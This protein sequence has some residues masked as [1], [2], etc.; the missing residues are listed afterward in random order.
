MR[1]VQ[2]SILWLI[3]YL[4]VIFE[5][6]LNK[7]GAWKA[8]SYTRTVRPFTPSPQLCFSSALGLCQSAGFDLSPSS[9]FPTYSF[10]LSLY[11]DFPSVADF[12]LPWA[13]LVVCEEQPKLSSPTMDDIQTLYQKWKQWLMSLNGLWT[14]VQNWHFVCCHLFFFWE[15]EVTLRV[16]LR[17]TKRWINIF[18]QSTWCYID[19][20]LRLEIET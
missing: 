12:D 10:P 17:T 7:R 16:E 15:T 2:M 1:P 19:K 20:D 11:F 6:N 13:M 9:H 18:L 8:L 4:F 14:T 5:P 3:I